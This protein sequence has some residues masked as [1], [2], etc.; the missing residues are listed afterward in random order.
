MFRKGSWIL[1]VKK[2][3]SYMMK[4]FKV[5]GAH[6]DILVADHPDKAKVNGD[7]LIALETLIHERSQQKVTSK[8]KPLLLKFWLRSKERHQPFEVATTIDPRGSDVQFKKSL[9]N[10]FSAAGIVEDFDLTSKSDGEPALETMSDTLKS[11]VGKSDQFKQETDPLLATAYRYIDHLRSFGLWIIFEDAKGRLAL[12]TVP[13]D[14]GSLSLPSTQFEKDR[15]NSPEM[16]RF[17]SDRNLQ[18]FHFTALGSVTSV[19]RITFALERLVRI[20]DNSRGS[21]IRK[22]ICIILSARGNGHHVTPDGCARL[23]LQFS[24]TWDEFLLSLSSEQWTKLTRTQKF[25]RFPLADGLE[26][27][28]RSLRRVS[29]ALHV[30]EVALKHIIGT[31]PAWCEELVLKLIKDEIPIRK[32]VEKY[33]LTSP[34]VKAAGYLCFESNLV[35]QSGSGQEIGFRLEP[36]GSL[37][38]S[39]TL[40]TA[41]ILRTLKDCHPTMTSRLQVRQQIKSEM[42]YLSCRLRAH[43]TI[44]PDWERESC[45]QGL[46]TNECLLQCT[47]MLKGA[48]NDLQ[49]TLNSYLRRSGL[50]TW[51][52][53]ISDRFE[54]TVTGVFL[55]PWNVDRTALTALLLG[56][57]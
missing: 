52:L 54:A 51:T 16:A 7:S 41:Q 8:E 56:A 36:T 23:A 6:P 29:D 4:R 45:E 13:E 21:I 30:H 25:Y 50:Q 31:D 33:K 28:K 3:L 5:S 20:F 44:D 17:L 24:Q 39:A 27:R 49:V 57:K 43:V 40:N 22:E 42:E 10:L 14:P 26:K 9:S 38:L 18:L 11:A 37:T 35:S 19:E 15:Y 48:L 12:I 2:P 32:T 34:V 1:S 53:V 46:S 55:I 47:S